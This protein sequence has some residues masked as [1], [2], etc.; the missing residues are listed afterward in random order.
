[1]SHVVQPDF[2]D[3][4]NHGQSEFLICEYSNQDGPSITGE[5]DKQLCGDA[6]L[7][8]KSRMVIRNYECNRPIFTITHTVHSPI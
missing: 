6:S 5:F 1:M 2:N 8:R 7:A 4:C 3:A